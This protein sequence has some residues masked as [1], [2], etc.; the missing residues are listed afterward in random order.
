M[1][2]LIVLGVVALGLMAFTL[3]NEKVNGNYKSNDVPTD[4]RFKSITFE[5]AKELAKEEDKLIFID[6]HT[7]WCGPCKKMAATSFKDD[8]VSQVFNERFISLKVDIEK[9]ADGPEL[10]RLYKIKAYPTCLI[11]NP[12]GKLLKERVGFMT[13]DQLIAFANSVN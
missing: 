13:S 8:E 2:K 5:A 4:I 7:S 9:D 12:N 3:S 10:A 6:C 11:L 1:K